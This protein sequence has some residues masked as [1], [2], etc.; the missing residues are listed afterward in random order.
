MKTV[1]AQKPG[2]GDSHFLSFIGIYLPITYVNRL[3][4][5]SARCAHTIMHLYYKPLVKNN[6]RYFQNINFFY[7]LHFML[8]CSEYQYKFMKISHTK[9]YVR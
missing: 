9:F 3:T 5:K 1:F 2:Y 7:I 6:E 8:K 4:V